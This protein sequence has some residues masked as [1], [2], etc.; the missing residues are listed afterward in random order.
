MIGEL[1]PVPSVECPPKL[2]SLLEKCTSFVPRNRP[3]FREI[4]D[5]LEDIARK[6]K[7]NK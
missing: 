2:R 7:A 5:S 3:T 1:K 4:K 6:I